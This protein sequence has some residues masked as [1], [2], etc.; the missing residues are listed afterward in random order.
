MVTE[1]NY[2]GMDL[3]LAS[4]A[5]YIHLK[6]GTEHYFNYRNTDKLSKWHKVV[7]Y[8]NY[9]SYEN[10]KIENSVRWMNTIILAIVCAI[11]VIVWYLN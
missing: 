11:I 5:I 6:D 2:I 1:Y 8:V 9:R 7:S 3:S 10:K 4:S